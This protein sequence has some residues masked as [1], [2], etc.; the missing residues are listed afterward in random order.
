MIK[1]IAILGLLFAL[2]TAG[3]PSHAE[4]ASVSSIGDRASALTGTG[5]ETTD[6]AAPTDA[7]EL[8]GRGTPC[9]R[10]CVTQMNVCANSCRDQCGMTEVSCIQICAQTCYDTGRS[11]VHDICNQDPNGIIPRRPR[12]PRL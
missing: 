4:T 2:G 1:N 9:I 6:R 7:E 12:L 5:T 8:Q 3:V 10:R 11:C